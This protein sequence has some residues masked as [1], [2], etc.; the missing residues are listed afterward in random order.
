MEQAELRPLEM[1]NQSALDAML[2]LD[3]NDLD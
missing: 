1:N 3:P 2:F